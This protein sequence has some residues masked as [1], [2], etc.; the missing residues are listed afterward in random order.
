[1]TS[2]LITGG[3][4]YKNLT[5]I[6]AAWLACAVDGEGWIGLYTNRL[7][8]VV[9]VGVCNSERNFVENA[10]MLMGGS[11]QVKGN[12]GLIH[13]YKSKKLM[14]RVVVKGHKHV[15]HILES[16]LPY[17]IIKKEKAQK[18][19]NFIRGREWG[20]PSLEARKRVSDAIKLSWQNQDIRER[21]IRG[22]LK[23]RKPC[24]DCGT[25]EGKFATLSLCR[26][27]YQRRRW[28]KRI[29]S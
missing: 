4:G 11:V 10:Q 25:L 1:M 12:R 8:P 29:S 15:L 19:I 20:K 23:Y 26:K 28:S 6:E 22:M 24:N 5:D 27:C 17:L 14:T 18:V 9:E 13:G 2:V 7:W 21:R 16:I 3:L